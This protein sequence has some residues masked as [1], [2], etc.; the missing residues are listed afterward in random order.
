MIADFLHIMELQE[1]MNERVSEWVTDWLIDWWIDSMNKWTNKWIQQN[2]NGWKTA[3]FFNNVGG[4]C[5]P[6]YFN[7]L[8]I[9]IYIYIKKSTGRIHFV[10]LSFFATFKTATLISILP[11]HGHPYLSGLLSSKFQFLN[12]AST[13][14]LWNLQHFRQDDGDGVGIMISVPDECAEWDFETGKSGFQFCL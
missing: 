1:K 7:K 8:Y 3:N 2:L 4:E 11:F 10:I 12:D 13:G 9:C 6:G 14:L 5:E